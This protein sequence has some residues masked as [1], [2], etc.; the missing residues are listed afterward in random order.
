MRPRTGFTLV[1]IL[2]V[3]VILAILAVVALPKFSNASA[4]ARAVMLKDDL[5]L[6]RSQLMVF[7]AQHRGVS[8]GYPNCDPAQSPTEAALAA[9]ITLASDAEGE[10]APIGT[11]G[12]RYGPY[13]RAMP[14]NPVNGKTS[15]LLIA[16]GAEFPNAPQDQHGWI[17]QPSTLT[18]KADISGT[19]ESGQAFFDY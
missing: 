19:D 18:F 3:V 1:E 13:M 9:H 15:V 7:K 11:L 8:A 5:R 10:T 16:D 12:Y 4:S 17:Y 14:E 2:I 6:M